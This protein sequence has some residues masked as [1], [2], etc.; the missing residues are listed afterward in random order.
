MDSRTDCA[1]RQPSLVDTF[2]GR[3]CF[4]EVCIWPSAAIGV[5][6]FYEYLIA[7]LHVQAELQLLTVDHRV[8]PG[9]SILMVGDDR[10]KTRRQLQ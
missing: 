9:S 8:A 5:V 1:R 6:D 7:A 10:Q 3:N 2:L 4:F